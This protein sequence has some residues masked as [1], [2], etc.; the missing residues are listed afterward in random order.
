MVSGRVAHRLPRISVPLE[1]T[2]VSDPKPAPAKNKKLFIVL[3]VFAVLLVAVLGAA[4]F[5]LAQRNAY[6]DEDAPQRPAAAAAAKQPPTYLPMDNMVVNLADPGGD[7]FAQIGITLE[8][9]DA[10]TAE[11]VKNFMPTIRSGV[12]M[13]VSQRTA[14][15]LLTREGKEALALEVRRAVSQPLGYRV[16][17]PRKAKARQDEDDFDDD[18]DFDAPR[19]RRDSNPVIAVLFSSF[20]I[21]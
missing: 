7:R 9:A 15:E 14:D 6:G 20:I 12:L 10:K 17:K 18:D 1:S 4:W 8:L 21:Q 2:N 3:V 5:F 19:A 13:L 16:S 11:Q